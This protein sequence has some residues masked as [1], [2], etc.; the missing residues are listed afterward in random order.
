MFATSLSAPLPTSLASHLFGR[1]IAP[2]DSQASDSSAVASTGAVP[3]PVEAQDD[4]AMPDLAQRVR[5]IG[6]W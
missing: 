3:N 6:E 1:F 2:S 4:E 5:E